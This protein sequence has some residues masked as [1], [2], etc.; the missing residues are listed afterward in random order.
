VSYCRQD[1]KK[2][3]RKSSSPVN[4]DLYD[5][6]CELGRTYDVLESGILI[7]VTKVSR[8]LAGFSYNSSTLTC[9]EKQ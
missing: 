5:F 7:Q 4:F 8:V 1:K 3:L 6:C 2:R 9:F